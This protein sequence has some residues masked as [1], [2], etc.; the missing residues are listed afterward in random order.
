MEN[1]SVEQLLNLGPYG[2]MI[3]FGVWLIRWFQKE[4]WPHY[5]QKDKNRE[6]IIMDAVKDIN[7]INEKLTNLEESGKEGVEQILEDFQDVKNLLTI[8][9][10]K[11]LN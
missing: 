7:S 4:Y 2:L 10:K 8:A 5:V 6:Q 1:F 11:D 9:L 3:L